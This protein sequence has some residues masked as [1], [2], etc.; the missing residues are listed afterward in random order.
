[1]DSHPNKYRKAGLSK[2]S[3]VVGYSLADL[4][5][6]LARVERR[7]QFSRKNKTFWY[8]LP[9]S[10]NLKCQLSRSCIMSSPLPPSFR[11]NDHWKCLIESN[12]DKKTIGLVLC[13][14]R[15]TFS[16]YESTLRRPYRAR[17]EEDDLDVVPE[18][19]GESTLGGSLDISVYRS[20]GHMERESQWCSTARLLCE[21]EQRPP[22]TALSWYIV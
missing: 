8:H 19:E 2:R 22:R 18:N 20:S 3:F 21:C 15:R 7:F 6:L 12:Y 5:E 4:V 1:M 11:A 16:L 13:S 10:L 17:N 14:Q 9:V